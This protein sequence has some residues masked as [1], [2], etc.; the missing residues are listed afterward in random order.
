MEGLL[1]LSAQKM[2]SEA[3][4][5]NLHGIA[6]RVS[7]AIV[8]AAHAGKYEVTVNKFPQAIEDH[9]AQRHFGLTKMG[10]NEIK[11]SWN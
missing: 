4:N 2:K 7:N 1:R 6:G 8:N 10:E 11:I 5:T 3:D 9:L